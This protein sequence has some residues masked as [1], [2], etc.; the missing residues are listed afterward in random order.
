MKSV[1]VSLFILM[2]AAACSNTLDVRTI[3]QER[4]RLELPSPAPLNLEDVQWLAVNNGEGTLYALDKE[5]FQVYNQNMDAVTNY[6]VIINGIL[7]EYR[8]YY[9]PPTEE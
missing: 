3:A 1:L 6:I 8:M 2:T 4:P 7:Y 5:N 9:E